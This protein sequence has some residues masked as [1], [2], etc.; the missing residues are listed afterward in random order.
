MKDRLKVVGRSMGPVLG[1]VASAI[2]G[3]AQWIQDFSAADPIV[4][5]EPQEPG[6]WSWFTGDGEAEMDFVAHDGYASIEVDAADD[7]LNIWWALI[8]HR[9]DDAVDM[10]QL[11]KPEYELRIEARVRPSAAPRRINLHFNTQRTDDFHSHLREY[12]LPVAHEWSV[13]SMTTKGFPVQPEDRLFCQ[14]ALM[15]WGRERFTLDIDYV[16]VDVVRADEVEPDLGD[17]QIYHPPVPEPEALANR[18]VVAADTVVDR[19]FPAMNLDRWG[20]GDTRRLLPVTDSQTPLLRW[21]LA[22][23]AGRRAEGVAVLSLTTES[24]YRI[25]GEFEEIGRVRVFEVLKGEADWGETT[26]TYEDFCDGRP[27][28][29]VLNGQMI[30]DFEVDPMPGA[31]NRIALP[32]AV[33]QRLL[34]GTTHS[35]ALRPLGPINATF[36]AQEAELSFNLAPAP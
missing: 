13:V 28:E 17:P 8:R 4:R 11:S 5:V 26:L 23:F 12:D 21:D 34:D 3:Q 32:R 19:A 18:V 20:A 29:S 6:G 31:V 1:W 15:D 25:F 10:A 16:R 22:P 9:I 35:L 24:I 27:L 36:V 33:M 7:F 30:I 2:P 14:M